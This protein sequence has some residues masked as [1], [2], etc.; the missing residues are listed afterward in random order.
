MPTIGTE[1]KNAAPVAM[2]GTGIRSDSAQASANRPKDC[3]FDDA[4]NRVM[5]RLDRT[6]AQSIVL[7]TKTW[8]VDADGPVEPDHDEGSRL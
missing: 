4:R 7:M 5:V 2:P 8:F 3:P 6:I 1:P